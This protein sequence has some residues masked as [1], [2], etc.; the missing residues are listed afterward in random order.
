L[1]CQAY[2]LPRELFSLLA[3]ITSEARIVEVSE[4]EMMA[5]LNLEPSILPVG[6][7]GSAVTTSLSPP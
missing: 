6:C 3:S 1:T 7:N 5:L 2:R 4:Q